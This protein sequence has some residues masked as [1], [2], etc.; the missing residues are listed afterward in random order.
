VNLT[1][2]TEKQVQDFEKDGFLII[3]N[4]FDSEGI[5]EIITW[6]DE[7]Q[8]YP[9][10]AG[11]YMM[12]FEDSLLQS[13]DR[14]LQR[15]ENFYPNP[16]GSGNY[17]TATIFWAAFPICSASPRYCSRTRSILNCLVAMGLNGTRINRPAGAL[18][19]IYSSPPWCALMKSQTITVLWRWPPVTTRMAW[20][21]KNG[22]LS[23]IR[24][25]Q[26]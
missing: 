9:E 25:W 26:E 13:G 10:A 21:E 2:L 16:K 23:L 14:I 4:G 22:R 11:K 5:A 20:L 7:V 1:F 17:L 3:K 19:R 8:N 18:M 12:C 24:K 15:L 6:T